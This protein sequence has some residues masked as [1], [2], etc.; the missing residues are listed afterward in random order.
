MA[1]LRHR[2]KSNRDELHCRPGA[3]V[4]RVTM[5]W[6]LLAISGCPARSSVVDSDSGT[7]CSDASMPH[8]NVGEAQ[9][10]AIPE[11]YD[12]VY[13]DALSVS[14]DGTPL[15]YF[16]MGLDHT[17][18]SY[19]CTLE[20]YSGVDRNGAWATF[21][22]FE[23]GGDS[24]CHTSLS[25]SAG[26]AT[27]SRLLIATLA[28]SSTSE[29]D[30]V[31]VYAGN[32][33]TLFQFE[34]SYYILGLGVVAVSSDGVFLQGKDNQYSYLDASAPAS[35]TFDDVIASGR[36]DSIIPVGDLNGDGRDEA[37]ADV[38][39]GTWLWDG[40]DIPA[41]GGLA[42]ALPVGDEAAPLGALGDV[43][44]DGYREFA[45]DRREDWPTSVL[46]VVYDHDGVEVS[47]IQT[48][49]DAVALEPIK[50]QPIGDVDDDAGEEALMIGSQYRSGDQTWLV[51]PPACGRWD[52]A[53]VGRVPDDMGLG[54]EGGGLTNVAG[55]VTLWDRGTDLYFQT[56]SSQ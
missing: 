4:L 42:G 34:V 45:V 19:S 44:G 39:G 16:V 53:D 20:A 49:G 18:G 26:W 55:G 24:G 21:D 13:E 52:L 23:D 50:V 35:A 2:R 40:E 51:R 7:S 30:T 12:G 15:S 56:L 10:L 11:D 22:T 38:G 27:P 3:R 5:P 41:E 1:V 46:L 37:L 28:R 43:D 9:W 32:G 29:W 14:E 31:S 25:G 8:P 47:G 33:D 6:V 48:I 54:A 36:A 17:D